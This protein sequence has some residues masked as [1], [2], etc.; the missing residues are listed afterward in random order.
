MR[1]T[2]VTPLDDDPVRIFL[3]MLK[4]CG[5]KRMEL[6]NR[7][8]NDFLAGRLFSPASTRCFDS[9]QV[10]ITPRA[11][12]RLFEAEEPISDIVQKHCSGTWGNVTFG[13][14]VLNDYALK[15]GGLV[16]SHHQVY[17]RHV[18]MVATRMHQ[19]ETLVFLEEDLW[20]W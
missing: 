17:E 7:L 8:W 1:P 14:T 4:S 6:S 15:F 19:K 5:K 10:L 13:D 11:K 3:R 16:L 18:V 2:S 12:R 20:L 9:G